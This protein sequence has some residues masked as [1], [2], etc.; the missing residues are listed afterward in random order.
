MNGKL[1]ILTAAMAAS[2]GVEARTVAFEPIHLKSTDFIIATGQPT[3]LTW[4]AGSWHVP[5]WSLSGGTVGQ[6][7]ASTVLQLPHSVTTC[8]LAVRWE[9][10]YSIPHT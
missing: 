7:V 2:C 4:P 5:V 8:D 3:L 6:S 1:M 9:N 10:A